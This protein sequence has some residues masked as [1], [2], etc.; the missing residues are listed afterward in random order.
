VDM[1]LDEQSWYV[2]R[3][4]PGVTGFVGGGTG[5]D[6]VPLP[7]E[8]LRYILRTPIAEGEEGTPAKPKITFN[9]GQ[10]VK[11]I[12]GPFTDFV[13]TVSEVFPDRD[14]VTVLVSFF[15]RETPVTLDFLQVEKI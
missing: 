6:A 2:V 4:T 7:E 13:G 5:T 9:V 11:V 8:E 3:N 12:D 14:K 10:N 15:G 1:V